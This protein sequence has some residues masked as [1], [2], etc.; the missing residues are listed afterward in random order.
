MTTYR[1]KPVVI[2][3]YQFN[4][5]VTNTPPTWMRDAVTL[6]QITIIFTG[7]PNPSHMDIETLEGTM[8][9]NIGDWI[10]KGLKGELYPCRDDI[11]QLTYD[12]VSCPEPGEGLVEKVAGSVADGINAAFGMINH[13]LRFDANSDIPN[14]VAVAVLALLTAL[15]ESEHAPA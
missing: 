5:R 7:S 10:I 11:F 13:P 2:E 1:K 6:D 9:A 12:P 15:M 14:S 3:A 8:R 4:N